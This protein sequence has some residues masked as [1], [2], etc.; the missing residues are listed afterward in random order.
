VIRSAL[1]SRANLAIIPM[2]DALGLDG[3]HRMN[4]P[5]TTQGNWNWRFQ[6]EEIEPDTVERLLHR[7]SIY[8]RC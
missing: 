2:Q 5:G 4:T 3:E 1:A 7:V 8:G 6:W